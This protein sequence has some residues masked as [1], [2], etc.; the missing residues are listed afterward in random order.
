[1]SVDGFVLLSVVL[2][3]LQCALCI[4][5]S[6]FLV[7]D[8]SLVGMCVLCGGLNG[9]RLELGRMLK[10][11]FKYLL[12]ICDKYSN[13]LKMPSKFC[14]GLYTYVM[15]NYKHCGFSIIYYTAKASIEV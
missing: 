10:F 14:Y 15:V 13:V 5:L 4:M 2:G 11:G 6:Y 8:I 1:M 9:F 7:G 12:Y 3:Y